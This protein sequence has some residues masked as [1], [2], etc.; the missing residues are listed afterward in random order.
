MSA[1][2]ALYG[3]QYLLSCRIRGDN[4]PNNAEY[5]GYL[6][7]KDLYPN[8]EF[9]KLEDY[10]NLVP[11][12]QNILGFQGMSPNSEPKSPANSPRYR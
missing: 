2:Y 4:A 7:V 5:L 12:S 8:I 11:E 10:V 3:Y 6:N 9:I 1:I